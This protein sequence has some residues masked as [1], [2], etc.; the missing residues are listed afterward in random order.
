MVSK[1]AYD[2]FGDTVVM[3]ER[4]EE[5]AVINGVRCCTEIRESQDIVP[6]SRA[7]MMIIHNALS[8]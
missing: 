8:Y 6:R 2:D 1:P 5:H 7:M 4:G 3:S